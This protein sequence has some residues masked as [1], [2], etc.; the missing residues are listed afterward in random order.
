MKYRSLF[1]AVLSA[2]LLT[3]SALA[4]GGLISPAPVSPAPAGD[5]TIETDSQFPIRVW[6]TASAPDQD[7]IELKND[8]ESDPYNHIVLSVDGDT[9]ILDAVTGAAAAL[10]DIKEGDALYAYVGP[11]MTRSMPPIAHASLILCNIPADYAAPTWAEVLGVTEKED[12]SRSVLMSGDVVLH[13]NADTAYLPGP[14]MPGEG[15]AVIVPGTRLLAWYSVVA[16]SMPAQ[17]TPDKVMVFS[18]PYGG[19]IDLSGEGVSLNGSA[20][21]LNAGQ[22]PFALDGRLMLPVRAVA[23]ALG[24]TVVWDPANPGQVAVERSGERLYAFSLDGGTVT[25]E[26][27]MVMSLA[28]KPVS[29]NGV[30]FLAAED[31]IRVHNLKLSQTAPF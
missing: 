5:Y 10:A 3:T 13:L 23:E 25:V 27:D 30:T 1:C 21:S 17:A 7:R 18:S 2:A 29:M 22:Q 15:P 16:P 14:G 4:S 11:A 12:G 19:W 26:G 20:L 8:D 31:V 6:G 28:H 24:C 9:L